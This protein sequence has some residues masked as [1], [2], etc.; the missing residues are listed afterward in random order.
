MFKKKRKD[1]LF[2][3]FSP[4]TFIGRYCKYRTE[5]KLWR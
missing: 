1:E 4:R 2:K 3:N 5:K